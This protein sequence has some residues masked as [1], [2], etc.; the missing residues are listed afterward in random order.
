MVA[1]AV[2]KFIDVGFDLESFG[3]I[4]DSGIADNAF[5]D[6]E[7]TWLRHSEPEKR[8]EN[9]LR[10]WTLK[11]A[12]IKATGRGLAQ[13]LDTFWFE[14]VDPPSMRF[15]DGIDDDPTAWHFEQHIVE[16]GFVSALAF[17]AAEDDKPATLWKRCT[18]EDIKIPEYVRQ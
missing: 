9:F 17:R 10:L 2:S 6:T 13:P 11:E 18:T 3:R 4:V 16:D 8:S 1:V 14:T 5:H 12:Y 15:S 7:K